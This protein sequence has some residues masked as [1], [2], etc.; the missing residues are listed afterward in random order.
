MA[1]C[2]AI[3]TPESSAIDAQIKVEERS[4]KQALKVLVLGTSAS[5]KSTVAKQMKILHCQ[6]FSSEEL[7]NYKQILI[8]NIFNGMKELVFQAEQFGIKILRKNKK[9]AAYFSNAN[10]Y[11]ETLN[12]DTVDLAKQLWA[13]K[14]THLNYFFVL[15]RFSHTILPHWR[16]Q[17]PLFLPQ[18]RPNSPRS[19]FLLPP[20]PFITLLP[21]PF[22]AIML[23]I[24]T[25]S[26]SYAF[27]FMQVSKRCGNAETKSISLPTSNT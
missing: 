4:N 1:C 26:S 25:N 20:L 15:L 6:G 17:S 22:Y 2:G 3:I 7:H 24:A 9:V 10:P 21:R 23:H 13:D 12:S 11:T 18:R 27:S 16:S 5:G 14:G 8:L 19:S